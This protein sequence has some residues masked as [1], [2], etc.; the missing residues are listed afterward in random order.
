MLNCFIQ[1]NNNH[2]HNNINKVCFWYSPKCGCTFIRKLYCYYTGVFINPSQP[3][4]IINNFDQYKHILFTRNPYKRIV[5]GFLD[6][7][8]QNEKYE[9]FMPDLTFSKFLDDLTTNDFNNIDHLH[10]Q[11]QL[12]DFYNKDVIFDRVFDIESIDYDY[13]NSLFKF[14]TNDN[15]LKSFRISGHHIKYDKDLM[16]EN[17]DQLTTTELRKMKLLPNSLSFLNDKNKEKIYNYYKND[18]DFFSSIGINY[19]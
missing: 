9:D 8:V 11:K 5:S 3:I 19:L 1:H 4:N 6:C 15:I 13:L 17:A 16:L 2:N 7:Y 14:Q 12:S 18:I 10:F